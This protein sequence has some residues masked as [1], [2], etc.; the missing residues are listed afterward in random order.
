MSFFDTM[1]NFGQPVVPLWD[2]SWLDSYPKD[3]PS[4]LSYPN[5]P[6]SDLLES[7]A[8]RFPNRAGCTL[9]GKPTTYAELAD[10]SHRLARSLAQLGAG[11]GRMVGMLLPNIPEYLIALQ[12]TWLTGATALQ[13][14]PLMVPEEIEKWLALTGCHIVVTLDLLAPGVTAGLGNGGPLEHV[15]VASLAG[16]IPR[17]KSWLYWVERGDWPVAVLLYGLAGIGFWG[18]T[19]FYDSLLPDVAEERELDIVSSYGYALGYLAHLIRANEILGETLLVMHN[20][21]SLVR[22]TS[23]ATR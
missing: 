7:A 3:V 14:S 17:W 15:I 20:L 12:A 2:R 19:T 4:S 8:R 5:V 16:R 10:K 6:V 23:D 1:T 22:A 13:L 21:R 18:G 9:Y 11:P